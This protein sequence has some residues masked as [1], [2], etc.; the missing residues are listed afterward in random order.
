MIKGNVPR[1]NSITFRPA[2]RFPSPGQATTA[3]NSSERRGDATPRGSKS[4]RQPEKKN[5]A[6]G[7]V[8]FW[9]VTL[10]QMLVVAEKELTESLEDYARACRDRC[11]SSLAGK[12]KPLADDV[13]A[14][15]N[16]LTVCKQL[17]PVFASTRPET[18]APLFA[19]QRQAVRDAVKSK[20]SELRDACSRDVRLTK[21][22]AR[23]RKVVDR[24]TAYKSGVCYDS[25][26]C[27]GYVTLWT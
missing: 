15:L 8:R 7:D 20:F 22:P 5:A 4:K 24:V 13:V 25:K 23:K 26:I 9:N 21:W 11:F 19:K 1:L 3:G 10:C 17:D 14:Y 2:D 27:F 18:G 6:A 12:P 16:T